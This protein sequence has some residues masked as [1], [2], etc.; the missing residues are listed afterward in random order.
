MG[1]LDWALGRPKKVEAQQYPAVAL[2]DDV[3]VV[4][5]S[6]YQQSFEQLFA[7]A[8]RPL[9]GQM[10]RVAELRPEPQNR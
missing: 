6:F 4:G 10:M 8:G 9:G 2:T 5:E 3:E 7:Q 1:L